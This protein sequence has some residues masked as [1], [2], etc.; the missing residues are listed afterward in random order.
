MKKVFFI[1]VLFTVLNLFE[2]I[3]PKSAFAGWV[4][5]YLKSNGTYVN[6]YYRTDP[7]EYKWN[8]YSFDNDWSDA[9]N[10]NTWYRSYGYDPE[11]FDDDYVSSYSRDYYYDDYDY[12][13]Y[14]YGYDSYDYDYYDSG[15]SWSDWDW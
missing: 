1:L 6:G 3:S 12:Y 9:Y 5:G 13:D 14:D 11:P 4:N 8:N 15:S 2:F 7:D 10:D